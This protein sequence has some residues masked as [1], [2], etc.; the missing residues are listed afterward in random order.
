MILPDSFTGAIMAAEGVKDGA[1]LMNGPTGCKFYHGTLADSLYPRTFSV[2]PLSSWDRFYFGQPRVPC[3]YL[4]EEE[5]ISGTAARLREALTAVSAKHP[6]LITVINSPG[7]ALI[8]DDLRRIVD[9]SSITVPVAVVDNCGFSQ[10]MGHGFQ[11][12]LVRMLE[13]LPPVTAEEPPGLNLVG[14]SILDHGWD[15]GLTF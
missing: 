14:V 11:E 2:D 4:Q 1:V 7:A 13:A 6:S 5:Y 12:C 8:G 10:D 15:H 9:E 3:T